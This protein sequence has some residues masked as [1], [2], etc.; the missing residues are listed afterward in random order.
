MSRS[1]AAGTLQGRHSFAF[2]LIGF[3]PLAAQIILM[4]ELL[5]IF[6]GNELSLG[7]ML[8]SWLLW[9]AL[10]SFTLGRF[11]DRLYDRERSL[12][13]IQA[14]L[15]L[16]LPLS[17]L[18]IRLS[19]SALGVPPGEIID[20]VGMVV[21]TFLVLGP[22]CFLSGCLFTLA[23]SLRSELAG[24]GAGASMG[25]VFY[26]EALG[27]GVGGLAVIAVFLL[28]L[29]HFHGLFTV[30]I[31]LCLS[32]L[33]LAPERPG[34]PVRAG[35]VMPVAMVVVF[36]AGF[37]AAGPIDR[38]TRQLEWQGYK[39][40]ES[41]DTPYGNL[42]VVSSG[43]QTSFFENGLWLFS[44][45]DPQ[46][47]EHAVHLALLQHREPRRVLL[48]GGGISGSLAEALK[49]PSV[50]KLDYVE[51]DP[52]I[53]S[54]GQRFLPSATRGVIDDPRVRIVYRDG[55]DHVKRAGHTYD[56]IIVDLPD[57]MTAQ[58]NRFYTA[59]FFSEV[60]RAL[61]EGGVFSLAVTSAETMVGP[62]LARLLSSLRN[63]LESVYHEVRVYPG[64]AARFSA[65]PSRDVLVEDP[66]IL[67]DRALQRNL[68]LHYV[69]DYYLL[70]NL[71]PQRQRFL[72]NILDAA[73]D[74]RVNRDLLPTLYYETLI[75]W[76]AQHTPRV[77]SIFRGVEKIT[78]GMVIIAGV[79][80]TGILAIYG[81]RRRLP[82]A[83]HVPVLYACFT[84]GY[85]EMTL[86]V[87]LI[88]T[89]QVFYGYV[90]YKIALLVTAYMV[91]LML[92]S[93]YVVPR[94]DG[95][96]DLSKTLALAQFCLGAYTFSLWGVILLIHG[97]H[98]QSWA[99]PVWELFF[100]VLMGVAGILGGIHFP[101]SGA[102]YAGREKKTGEAAGLIYGVDL[103]GSALGALLAGLMLLPG[104]G[105][106]RTLALVSFFNLLAAGLLILG[107]RPR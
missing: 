54:L 27:A 45:P 73:E 56:V 26:L 90:Y 95:L 39:L 11:S 55:R 89:F 12:A 105:I 1:S 13:L 61:N 92:G 77:A 22:C 15:A 82:G 32:A 36:S 76:S 30:S 65:S 41:R 100:P 91:G 47:A 9:T 93:R 20:P 101:L 40:L 72:E 99:W 60:R 83:A 53:I 51:L 50:E 44:W 70:F 10:G 48:V 68:D 29:N 87:L 5:V 69:R 107:K 102:L 6:Y 49:H 62:N 31:L 80:V 103:A 33:S 16:V 4:R 57:P 35:I 19:K 75:F 17:I 38:G 88:L 23:C 2:F 7:V 42:T 96:A 94:L 34:K 8:C 64:S 25:T 81:R 106:A 52:E 14:V 24:G 66:S 59:E 86:T 84:A 43:G 67:V 21:I 85:T 71:S 28:P 46:S 104:L 63:T 79:V 98:P 18:L 3:A 58:V 74:A 78:L 37:F 97:A